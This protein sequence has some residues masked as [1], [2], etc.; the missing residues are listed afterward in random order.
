MA[1]LML[2]LCNGVAVDRIPMLYSIIIYSTLEI[3]ILLI[4]AKKKKEFIEYFIFKI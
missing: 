3:K 2:Q 4:R 1:K